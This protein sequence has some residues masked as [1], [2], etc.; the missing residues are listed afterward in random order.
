MEN[1]NNSSDSRVLVA[2]IFKRRAWPWLFVL[3]AALLTVASYIQ[4]AL[5]FFGENTLCPFCPDLF[6]YY[7]F[8]HNEW[9][10]TTFVI[11]C[12]LVVIAALCA[13]LFIRKRTL[14]VTTTA[15]LF[16]KGNQSVIQIPF[17]TIERIDSGA[18]S[19]IVNVPFKKFKFA[20]L[21]NK[22]EL[23]DVLLAQLTT[24]ATMLGYSTSSIY[25]NNNY[26]T[27]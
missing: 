14:I 1:K 4:V 7:F 22:K 24:P 17:S 11:V 21:E 18:N 12:A 10:I 8:H 15:I 5:E 27:N 23:Y 2:G 3:L 9:L 13:I 25:D 6:T 26:Y 20:K 19:L 16:K